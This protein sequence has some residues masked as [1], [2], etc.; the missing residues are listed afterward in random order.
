MNFL[1]VVIS[2]ENTEFVADLFAKPT[3]CHHFLEFNSAHPYHTKR[4]S[5]YSQGLRI[6]RLCSKDSDFLH[7][8]DEMRGWFL[9]RG[10]PEKLIDRQL[11]RVKA[12]PRKDLV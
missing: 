9:N 1:D 10:Y 2:L 8:M 11:N 7:H 3:D 12:V 6:K 4:S 5:V